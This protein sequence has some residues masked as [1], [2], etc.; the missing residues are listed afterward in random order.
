MKKLILLTL[1]ILGGCA[2]KG[3]IYQKDLRTAEETLDKYEKDTIAKLKSK[4]QS[5]KK[6]SL[7]D[8]DRKMC[9]ER[10]IEDSLKDLP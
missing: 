1:L 5:V 10:L 9:L 7:P 3:G 6:V 8:I 4:K 2:T